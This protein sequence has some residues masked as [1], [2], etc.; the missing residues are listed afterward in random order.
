MTERAP[1]PPALAA[2]LNELDKGEG[3]EA[4][5]ATLRDHVGRFVRTV[6]ESGAAMPSGPVARGA[7]TLSEKRPLVE[8]ALRSARAVCARE[9]AAAGLPDPTAAV[10]LNCVEILVDCHL[11]HVMLAAQPL[12]AE[13]NPTPNG[14]RLDAT[15]DPVTP[16]SAHELG[17]ALGNYTDQTVRQRERDG[18]LFSILRPG[19]K[20]GAEYPAFQAW[21]GIKGEPLER[22]LR[23]LFPEGPVSGPSA[24]GF[25][26]SPSELLGGLT[27]VE[28]LTGELAK[29]RKV[30]PPALELLAAPHDERLRHVLAAAEVFCSE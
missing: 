8:E 28:A 14:E 25:F 12:P 18:K 6:V 29:H 5:L 4:P 20:R 27:P 21:D 19:R 2:L 26:T 22:V 16:L 7:P 30:G 17:V 15:T 1:A 13:E 10:L 23:R 3:G 9:L 11:A 24:Y